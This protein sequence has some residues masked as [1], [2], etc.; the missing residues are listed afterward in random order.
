MAWQV[1]VAQDNYP[2][3][4][5]QP[6]GPAKPGQSQA[7]WLPELEFGQQLGTYIVR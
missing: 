3:S 4:W 2:Q 5:E 1:P 7:R 6:K